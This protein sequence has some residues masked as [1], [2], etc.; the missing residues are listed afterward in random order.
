MKRAMGLRK[1]VG[2]RI[3]ELRT[4][5]RGKGLSQ[6]ALAGKLQI[7]TNTISRWETG[8]YRPSI[9]DLEMLARFFGI[10]I[11]EFFPQDAAP[12]KEQRPRADEEIVAELLL[13]MFDRPLDR[14]IAC[15]AAGR[16]EGLREALRMTGRI[17]PAYLADRIRARL[18]ELEPKP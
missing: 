1:Q 12:P 13:R 5:Y 10:S 8:T 4:G 2:D 3:R 16:A 9:E 17:D 18:R 6:E 7:A 15:V 11:S 14:Y